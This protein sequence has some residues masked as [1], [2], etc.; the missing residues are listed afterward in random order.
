MF[1]LNPVWG[2]YI[3]VLIFACLNIWIMMNRRIHRRVL[4]ENVGR[5]RQNCIRCNVIGSILTLTGIAL[6][7]C[8]WM[9]IHRT[10]ALLQPISKMTAEPFQLLAVTLFI[11]GLTT[12][13]TG[14]SYHRVQP[15]KKSMP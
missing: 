4:E 12:V 10:P 13:M 9:D 11:A 5:F 14:I 15:K 1:Q 6:F 3:L 2:I 8:M 7:A